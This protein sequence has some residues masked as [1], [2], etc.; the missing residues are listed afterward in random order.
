MVP[1]GTTP[2][3]VRS[4]LPSR[5]TTSV[6]MLMTPNCEANSG[7]LVDVDLADLDAGDGA[8]NLIHDGRAS[9][10]RC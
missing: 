3:E 2:T 10:T 5:M 9:G 6:G 1:F 7:L 4:T 8:G